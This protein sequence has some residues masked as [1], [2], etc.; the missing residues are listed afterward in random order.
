MMTIFKSKTVKTLR[1]ER[2]DKTTGKEKK[3]RSK[4]I[5]RKRRER[6][7]EKEVEAMT[8]TSFLTRC[9]LSF[10]ADDWYFFSRYN[11]SLQQ[12]NA[13]SDLTLFSLAPSLGRNYR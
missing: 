10:K 9:L 3:R 1:G 8:A 13:H 7:G 12:K 4:R 5:S 2:P 6:N 11:R